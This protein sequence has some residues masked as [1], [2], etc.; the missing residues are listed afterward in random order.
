MANRPVH[1]EIYADDPKR[2]MTFYEKLFGWKF[3]KFGG[4]IDYWLVTTGEKGT[5]GIDGGLMRR[6][7]PAPDPKAPTPVISWVC[8]V[9]VAD[10]DKAMMAATK[11]GAMPA[12]PKNAI[13]GVGW[14]AY[15]K[16]T[17]G[18]IFGVYQVDPKAK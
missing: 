17:E 8:T 18:N 13:P 9:D 10:I 16:D 1:F 3:Q 5:P 14:S 6:I 15:F 12:L 2:A 7:G 11:A 4:P